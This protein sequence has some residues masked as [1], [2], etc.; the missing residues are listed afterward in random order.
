MAL[1]FKK[2]DII[3]PDDR[4]IRDVT[5]AFLKPYINGKE[6]M[7]VE[8]EFYEDKTDVFPAEVVEGEEPVQAKSSKGVI[9]FNINANLSMEDVS[10]EIYTKVSEKI[11]ELIP[12]NKIIIDGI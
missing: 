10:N 11:L 7:Q 3:T 1:I 4:I 6:T 5:Y 8:C 2:T 12:N 9:V